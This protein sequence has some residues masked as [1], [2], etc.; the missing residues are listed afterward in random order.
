MGAGHVDEPAT[1]L[2]PTLLGGN[3]VGTVVLAIMHTLENIETLYNV[4]VGEDEERLLK[5]AALA[6]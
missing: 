6:S 2:L 5:R 4:S 1:P 3:Q